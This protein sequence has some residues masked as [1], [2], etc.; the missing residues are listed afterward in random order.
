MAIQSMMH[1]YIHGPD[2]LLTKTLNELCRLA[3]FHPDVI[4][5][6]GTTK[7]TG[8][9]RVLLEKLTA[10]LSDIGEEPDFDSF[11]G[12]EYSLADI[13]HMVEETSKTVSE[14]S[15][16]RSELLSEIAEYE[17]ADIQLR[18]IKNMGSNFDNIFKCNFVKVR[19]GRLP[20]DSFVKLEYFEEQPFI[21]LHYDFDGEFY[22]GVYF[23]DTPHASVVDEIFHDLYFERIRVPDFAHGSPQDA[24]ALFAMYEHSLKEELEALTEIYGLDVSV[25]N[26]LKSMAQYLSHSEKLHE[27]QSYATRLD[28]SFYMPGYVPESMVGQLQKSLENLPGVKI[29][30]QNPG[31][32]TGVKP[33]T[34]LKNNRLTKPFEF[35]VK[36]YG[37]PAS[38]GIDPTPI[39]AMTYTILFGIMF[40]D[41]GQGLTLSAIGLFLAFKKKMELGAILTR[42]GI[43]SAIFG[44]IFG[45]VFG[46]ETLLTPMFIALGFDGNPIHAL[47]ADWAT[48]LLI[49]A[50]GIG[51]LMTVMVMCLN[52]F[53]GIKQG[54]L[55]KKIFSPSGVVG[56]VFYICIV[57]AILDA[58]VLKAGILPVVLVFLAISGLCI[59]FMEPL[60]H[61]IQGH[62]IKSL[63]VG[64][65]IT[66][67][68]VETFEVLLTYMTNTLSYL[69][70][71]GFV[72]VH[73]G[74]MSVVFRIADL[75]GGGFA[76]AIVIIIGNIF[77]MG[78]E[79]LIVG[80]QVLRLEFY[81][82]FSR[83]YEGDGKPFT[84][85]CINN[86]K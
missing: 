74:M 85:L 82:M 24:L 11:D 12:T 26:K 68:T 36:M 5:Q 27:L 42:V 62:S 44:L 83:Y 49:I 41:V 39:V 81:E 9:H 50:V 64:E 45:S 76:A 56:L 79:G 46:F 2:E 10:L 15:T 13:T 35:F 7:A 80:I 57:L 70:V 78:M 22:W 84:P 59:V 37:L 43:S 18:H 20:K 25:I 69:R 86:E 47:S 54:N 8:P 65:V 34:L 3:C 61:I 75:V 38:D 21:F 19:F 16:R 29:I 17:R 31:A 40:A 28:Y 14:L 1:L 66:G 67:A 30:K 53:T 77:V 58:L 72:L 52:I 73:A 32:E 33:P 71:G 4:T 48:R 60:S 51:V 55:A 6:Q 23:T 63:K